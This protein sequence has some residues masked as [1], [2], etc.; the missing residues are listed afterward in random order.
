M[1]DLIIFPGVAQNEI[2]R[3]RDVGDWDCGSSGV[4]ATGE[5]WN[6]PGNE[7]GNRDRGIVRRRDRGTVEEFF[8]EFRGAVGGGPW[9]R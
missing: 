7:T 8:R 1:G 3:E 4:E 9:S 2:H 6:P 5:P